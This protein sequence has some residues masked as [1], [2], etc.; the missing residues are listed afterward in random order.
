MPYIGSIHG[1]TGYYEIYIHICMEI[2]IVPSVNS[3]VLHNNIG[4]KI[5]SIIEFPFLLDEDKH[6]PTCGG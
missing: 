1:K 3:A 2:F 4:L 6:E 5:N